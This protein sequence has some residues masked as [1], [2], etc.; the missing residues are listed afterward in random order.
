MKRSGGKVMDK[1]RNQKSGV[2]GQWSVVKTPDS[3]LQTQ[4]YR[5]KTWVLCLVSC[6][7]ISL[8]T[9]VN[10]ADMP[11]K[12]KLANTPEAV[13]KGKVID[14]KRCSFC[15]GLTGA[16]DGP[17]ADSL[18]PRPRDFTAGTYKFR[19]TQSGGLPTDE[20][21]FRTTSRGLN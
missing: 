18:D 12:A 9:A 2:S 10:A 7:C 4:D 15:H 8:F 14:F 13:E 6:V 11:T 5:L 17:A 21:L 20:D 3:R 1:V 19:T 16:G